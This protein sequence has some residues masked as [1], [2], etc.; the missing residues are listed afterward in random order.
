METITLALLE[1]ELEDRVLDQKVEEV[2]VLLSRDTV[3]RREEIIRRDLSKDSKLFT[4][5]KTRSQTETSKRE[6][7]K[8]TRLDPML[9]ETETMI[10]IRIE[11]CQETIETLNNK[12]M[13]E[14]QIRLA[15]DSLPRG[16]TSRRK[17][18][19]ADL[20]KV[21]TRSKSSRTR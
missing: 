4:I 6:T 12:T 11:V 17:R 21:S 2:P 19:R 7:A 10:N 16:N 20:R 13:R 8:G 14:K 15:K 9:P 18:N 5:E 1:E 3:E